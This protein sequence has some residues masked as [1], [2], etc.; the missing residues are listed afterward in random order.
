[1]VQL[2]DDDTK[3]AH[4][5]RSLKHLLS[6][7]I[8]PPV[9][10]LEWSGKL[11]N[12]W[13]PLSGIF[14]VCVSRYV[15]L[16]VKLFVHTS[17]MADLEWDDSSAALPWSQQVPIILEFF[18]Y[19][20]SSNC[21][22]FFDHNVFAGDLS[23]TFFQ[24]CLLW[25]MSRYYFRVIISFPIV[26]HRFPSFWHTYLSRFLNICMSLFVLLIVQLLSFSGHSEGFEAF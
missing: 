13:L 11:K 10:R 20:S 24:R 5:V 2:F 18:V 26:S 4:I 8:A 15:C 21:V 19:L 23:P 1:M 25:H 3:H 12:T 14:G 17:T 16:S 22:S 6:R 7:R 9:R